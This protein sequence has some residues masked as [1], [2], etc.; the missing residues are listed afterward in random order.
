[1]SQATAAGTMQD[2]YAG[3]WGHPVPR[4]ETM[5]QAKK[6][7]GMRV[8][9]PKWPKM[10]PKNHGTALGARSAKFSSD[11]SR[12]Y[13]DCRPDEPSARAQG[14]GEARIWQ[15]WCPKMAICSQCDSLP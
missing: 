2:M 9:V 5:F 13:G 8:W 10:T 4:L 7:Q 12:M 11:I 3:R 14:P 6:G 15:H 1:M